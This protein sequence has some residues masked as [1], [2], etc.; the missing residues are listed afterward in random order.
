MLLSCRKEKKRKKLLF[1]VFLPFFIFELGCQ[2]GIQTSVSFDRKHIYSW[3]CLV[4]FLDTKNI[5]IR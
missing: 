3:S 5:G 2:Y 4:D 1:T